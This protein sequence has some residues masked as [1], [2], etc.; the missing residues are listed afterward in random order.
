MSN[1]KK[2]NYE[3]ILV[4]LNWFIFGFIGLDRLLVAYLIPA[5]MMD[6]NLTY[7]QAGLIV[8]IVGFTWGGMALVGGGLSNRYGRK[9]MIIGGTLLFSSMSWITGLLGS[10]S[11]FMAV[12][13][14]LG[15]GE[16]AY[17]SSA[18]STICEEATPSRRGL[19]IGIYSSS[20]AVIGMILGPI[21]ALKVSAA[22][23]WHW[24]FYITIIPGLLLALLARIL[25]REPASTAALMD[26]R[27]KGLSCDI[28]DENND[29]VKWYAFL[30]YRNITIAAIACI[31]CNGWL[32]TFTAFAMSFLNHD[33]GISMS[34]AGYVMAL[35]GI[36]AAVGE[37][38][39]GVVSDH[40]GRKAMFILS[41]TFCAIMTL[42]F[43]FAPANLTTLSLIIFVM[44][45]AGFAVYCMCTGILPSE[46]VPFAL[47]AGSVGFVLLI[48]E[49]VG[50]G[51]MPVLG[52]YLADTIGLQAPVILAGSIFMVPAIAGFF[53]KETAP[54]LVAKKRSNQVYPT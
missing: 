39:G 29:K 10:F 43:A 52:G 3:Y 27:K 45:V 31:C 1:E 51:L 22:L 42:A 32:Y 48:G 28:V 9:N 20:F 8:S 38:L 7:S 41:C 23:S 14:I 13:G 33:R 2:S 46:S 50:A 19:L 24:A 11:S 25:I 44:G 30:N 49:T 54:R 34:T 6:V 4:G 26:A 53:L 12:R 37:I 5:I 47:A 35:Y 18:V 16:G 40:I 15:L 21:Y 36:G 17:Y